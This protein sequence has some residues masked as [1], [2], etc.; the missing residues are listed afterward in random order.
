MLEETD[1]VVGC[2][3]LE[4]ADLR[5]GGNELGQKVGEESDLWLVGAIKCAKCGTHLGPFHK[6]ISQFEPE[7]HSGGNWQDCRPWETRVLPGIFKVPHQMASQ[8]TNQP[9]PDC[10][11]HSTQIK[12]G[13]K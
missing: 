2:L 9:L 6:V 3:G 8:P 10:P 1:L 4:N 5:E 13:H 11:T 12:V 7:L